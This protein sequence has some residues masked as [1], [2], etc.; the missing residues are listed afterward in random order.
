MAPGGEVSG[1]SLDEPIGTLETAPTPATRTDTLE[2]GGEAQGSWLRSGTGARITAYLAGL[3]LW[4]A[5]AVF[6]DIPGPWS[7]AYNLVQEFADGEVFSNFAVTLGR[8][9]TGVAISCVVGIIIGLLVGLS[10]LWRAA[11]GDLLLVALSIPA[12]IWAFLTV[13]WFG[14][15]TTTAVA[16]TV[17]T[18]TPFV[19]VNVYQGVLAISRDLRDMTRAYHVPAR[20]WIRHL[21]LPAIAGYVIAGVRFGVI[22]GW[23]AVLLAEWFGASDGVG[24][25][26]RYWYDAKDYGG[27]TAWV[28]LFIV[29]IVALDSLVL[30]R[31]SRRAFVW[32]DAAVERR[33]A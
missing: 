20:R 25:R 4:T 33:G 27:F 5:L 29:F 19:A 11:L 22:L 16:T 23:N 2:D 17:L 32:R 31:M 13:M 15:G 14:L 30:E 8:F 1:V 24:F 10:K 21:A 12:I 28:I 7:T 9:F 3:A 18:A 6:E 26:A